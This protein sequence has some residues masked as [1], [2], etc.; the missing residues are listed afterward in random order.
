MSA[1]PGGARVPGRA[2]AALRRERRGRGR[3]RPA[4]SRREPV[5]R[6]QE[7]RQ[8]QVDEIDVRQSEH[9]VPGHDHPLR[10]DVVDDVEERRVLIRRPRPAGPPRGAGAGSESAGDEAVGR[11]WAR[12]PDLEA[13]IGGA[14]RLGPHGLPE[15]RGACRGHEE[16]GVEEEGGAPVHRDRRTLAGR[17]GVPGQ[18]AVERGR[19]GLR[20]AGQ[21]ARRLA[22]APAELEEAGPGARGGRSR[23]GPPPGRAGPWGRRRRRAAP[24]RPTPLGPPRRSSRRAMAA[25]RPRTR[26]SARSSLE[27]RVRSR[28]GSTGVR[29][30]QCA[31]T[32]ECATA[33]RRHRVQVAHD[34]RQPRL[35]V[36][37]ERGV[38][39]DQPEP[40]A[41][42]KGSRPARA[43]ESRRRAPE[44]RRPG[45]ARDAVDVGG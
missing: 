11:P 5:G 14:R 23:A 8:A 10:E 45:A 16:R 20:A 19:G 13:A 9:D 17:V 33:Q 18:R 6:A 2:G 32:A 44:R 25:R 35:A 27:K 15:L 43:G 41:G 21:V 34:P 31:M 30:A 12:Q 4:L 39:D 29:R 24:G 28:S 40:L 42:R 7:G 37:R 36:L 3:S 22:L 26:A 1:A 38:G